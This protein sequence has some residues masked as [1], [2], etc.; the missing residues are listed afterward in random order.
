ML[1]KKKYWTTVAVLM[2]LQ[3]YPT[4]LRRAEKVTKHYFNHREKWW[5]IDGR[6]LIHWTQDWNLIRAA[7]GFRDGGPERLDPKS[8]A[9]RAISAA[10]DRWLRIACAAIDEARARKTVYPTQDRYRTCYVGEEG[11]TVYVTEQAWPPALV[12]CFRVRD[13][14]RDSKEDTANAIH[15]AKKQ[16]GRSDRAA[17]RRAALRSSSTK[18]KVQR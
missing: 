3:P 17:V 6:G 9:G 4:W 18:K 5:E 16:T 7:G 14:R 2:E 11:V 8:P 15:R 12:T 10:H 13:L 1:Q